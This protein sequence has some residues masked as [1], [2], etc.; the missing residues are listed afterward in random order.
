MSTPKHAPGGG[1]R[2]LTPGPRWKEQARIVASRGGGKQ[3]SHPGKA[4]DAWRRAAAAAD[5]HR[6]RT[7]KARLG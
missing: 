7:R 5:G 4:P 1:K 6:K 2:Q 3:G